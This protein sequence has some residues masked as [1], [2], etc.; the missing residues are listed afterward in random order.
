V[1]AVRATHVEYAYEIP[2]VPRP[3]PNG[4]EVLMGVDYSAA[5]VFRYRALIGYQARQD[6]NTELGTTYSPVPEAFVTRTA[7]HWTTTTACPE[8]DIQDIADEKL[9]GVVPATGGLDADLEYRHHILL[10]AHVQTSK[11]PE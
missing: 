6:Q 5:G 3:D 2:P 9:T 8:R 10:R 7:T 11:Q 4:G 1:V